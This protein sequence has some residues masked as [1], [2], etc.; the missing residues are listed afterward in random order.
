MEKQMDM[1]ISIITVCLNSEATIEQTIKSVLVQKDE[2]VEYIIV[3]GNSMDGT[4]KIVDKY[5]EGIDVI[6]SEPD[7]G[8]YDAMNKGI[9]LAKGEIIGIINSDDWY[10]PGTFKTI[11]ETFLNSSADIVYG[12]MNLVSENGSPELLVPTDIEKLRYEMEIPHSTA[13]VRKDIYEKFGLFS[14]DYKIAA[15]Y[16][17]MLRYYS[18]GVKFVFLNELLAN[19]RMGGVSNQQSKVCAYET[20]SISKKYLPYCPSDKRADL[21]KIIDN[22]WKPFFFR[23][24]LDEAPDWF[25]DGIK[26]KLHRYSKSQISIFG[27]GTW[28]MDMFKLLSGE[29]FSP[30]LFV[31]N[32]KNLWEKSKETIRISSPDSLRT[33]DGILLILAKGFSEEILLQVKGLD[34]PMLICITW[35]ELADE[36]KDHVF[37]G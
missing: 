32:N 12:K 11:R 8:I 23:Q 36:F 17:L 27:A 31:D 5:R 2:H 24:L 16:D 25:F 19:F 3:D 15:D 21:E 18:E 22:K 26:N 28:G 7:Q 34:N 33:F 30:S 6:V 35:E 29:G 1:K 4:R 9:S 13:F 14:L 20:I 10:E 37:P